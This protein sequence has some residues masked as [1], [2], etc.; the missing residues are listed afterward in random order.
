MIKQHTMQIKKTQQVL[1]HRCPKCTFPDEFALN[2]CNKNYYY[3]S[4]CIF[5]AAEK[6]NYTL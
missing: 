1:F 3:R 2:Q 5:Y 4:I 6:I